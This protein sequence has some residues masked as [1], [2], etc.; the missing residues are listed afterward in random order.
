MMR[1]WRVFEAP[2]GR[3]VVEDRALADVVADGLREM[4]RGGA[5]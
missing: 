4:A 3:E 5:S 1:R 2:E